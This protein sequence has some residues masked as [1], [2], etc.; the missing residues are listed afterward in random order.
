MGIKVTMAG[1]YGI[2]VHLF[3]FSSSVNKKEGWRKGE[4]MG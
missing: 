1:F 4:R 3:V 2:F